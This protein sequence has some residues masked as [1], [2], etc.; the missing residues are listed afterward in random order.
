MEHEVFVPV[1]APP[2]RE[3]LADPARVA[4]AVPGFQRD[5]AAGEDGP[6]GGTVSGDG[7]PVAGRLRLRVGGHSITYRGTL[8]LSRRDDGACTVEAEAAE[9]RGTGTARLS[10]TLRVHETGGGATLAFGGTA[11]ADGRVAALPADTVRS[12]VIRLLNRFA[13]NLAAGLA[14]TAPSGPPSAAAAADGEA[15]GPAGAAAPAG[16]P[17]AAESRKTADFAPYATGEFDAAPDAGDSPAPMPDG[18]HTAAT[19]GPSGRDTARPPEGSEA[20][21]GGVGALSE[22]EAARSSRGSE[23]GAGPTDAQAARKPGSGA[24]TS[25]EEPGPG[26]GRREPE[27]AGAQDADGEPGAGSAAAAERTSVFDVEVPPPSLDP[28]ADADAD[29][30]HDDAEDG[31]R[32]D[33]GEEPDGGDGDGEPSRPASEDFADA[34]EPPAEAAHARRTMIGRSAEEVDHAPPRGRY[35]PVPAPLTVSTSPAL[36]WAAPAAAVVVASA[37]VLARVLRRRR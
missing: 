31:G 8:R 1:P 9:S 15:T 25:A 11:T 2:L 32:G 26:V 3:A 34:A 37:I 21:E 30:A 27:G 35:A 4:R 18:D 16:T 19:A 17:G 20:A 13:E 12:A 23:G 6:G 5:A 14:D 10:L 22:G 7:G 29:D 28:L 24:G 36:R 33:G